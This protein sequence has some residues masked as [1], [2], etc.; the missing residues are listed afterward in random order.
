M[1]KFVTIVLPGSNRILNLVEVLV[2]VGRP[3]A[4]CIP[5]GALCGGAVC[6]DPASQATQGYSALLPDLTGLPRGVLPCP[7][8]NNYPL[9]SLVRI[10]LFAKGHGSL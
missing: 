8:A 2:S 1:G 3:D 9:G 5:A 6:A 7:F 4:T 10:H